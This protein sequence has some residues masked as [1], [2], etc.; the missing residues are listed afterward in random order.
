MKRI[1]KNTL[2]FVFLF[3]ALFLMSYFK[4]EEVL[5]PQESQKIETFFANEQ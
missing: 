5:S 2:P 3:S 1:L 4:H